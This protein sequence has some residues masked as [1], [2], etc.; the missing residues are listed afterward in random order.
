LSPR[1]SDIQLLV[2]E[3][4]ARSKER[5]LL[6]SAGA[7]SGKTT[8]LVASVIAALKANVPLDRLLVVTFTD[9]AAAEMKNKIYRAMGADDD[10]APLRLR[11]PQAWIST[12][13]SFCQRLLRDHFEKAGVDPRF[14]VLSE[15]D[16]RLLLADATTR[17]FHEHYERAAAEDGESLFEQ[18]VEMCG[19]GRD[20]ENLRGVVHALL[21]YARAS[22][23]P[24]RFL[25]GHLGRLPHRATEWNDL[26]WREDYARRTAGAW[27]AATGMLRALVAETGND[28]KWAAC[29][30]GIESVDP[31]L[32]A[33]P[34]GQAEAVTRL[35]TMGVLAEDGSLRIKL[36][37]VPRGSG[38]QLS[39]LRKSIKKAFDDEWLTEMP[40]DV[41]RAVKDEHSASRYGLCLLSLAQS[42]LEEY[43]AAKSRTGRLDFEDL[44]IR[45]LRLIREIADTGSAIRFERVFIDEFQDVNGLQHRLLEC[46]CDPTRIFRVGDVKQSI[47]Q[48]RL[49]DPGI[50]RDLGVDRPV[51]TQ[52]EGAPEGNPEWNVLLPA[53]YR[54]LRPIL[55]VVNEIARGLFFEEEIGTPYELQAL[56]PGRA[57]EESAPDVELMLVPEEDPESEDD[58]VGEDDAERPDLRETEWLAIAERIRELARPGNLIRDPESGKMRQIEYSDIAILLRAQSRAPAL[59]RCLEEEGI[60]CSV[61]TGESFFNATEVRDVTNVLRVADNMLDDI[62]LAAALRSPAL[63]W[64]DA[65]ILSV[66]LAYPRALHLAFALARLAERESGEARYVDALLPEDEKSRETLCGPHVSLP[67]E[68][69]FTAVPG[70]ARAAL[71]GFLRWRYAAGVCE[72]PELVARVLRETG[73]VRSVAS[74]PGGLR[75]QANLRKFVGIARRYAQESGHSLNRFLR[76]LDLL[77]E[78]GAKIFEAPL[79]GESLP[80]VRILTIHKAKGLEFPVV[81]VA[82]MGRPYRLGGRVDAIAPGHHYIGVR[83]LDQETYVLRK[84]A[85]LRLLADEARANE[86]A[87]EKRVLYVALTRARDRLILSG[88]LSK[89]AMVPD[90]HRRVFRRAALDRDAVGKAA[91]QSLLAA[92]AHP[93]SWV[94]YTLPELP[95]AGG[96]VGRLPLLV[97]WIRPR[98][99]TETPPASNPVREIE[100]ALRRRESVDV[101]GGDDPAVKDAIARA[102]KRPALPS[103]GLLS[104]ARGKIW[105]TEFKSGLD[106]ATQIDPDGAIE[107]GPDEPAVPLIARDAAAREGTLIHAALERLDMTGLNGGNLDARLLAAAAAIGGLPEEPIEVLRHGIGRLLDLPLGRLLTS[108]GEIHREVA[109]S[110]RLPLL[111]IAR[112]LPDLRAEIIASPDWKEWIEED[113]AGALRIRPE[114]PPAAGDPWV[115]VQGRIDAVLR[116]ANGWTVLD[117]KSD[118]VAG[119]EAI[120][121]R[122]EAYT[123][124]ME[125]YRRAAHSLFGPPVRAVVFFLRPGVLREMR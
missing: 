93:I 11:L 108:G 58:G 1:L 17:V 68:P 67:A 95:A 89:R 16:A 24:E 34:E 123:G 105:A 29:L 7:G 109:F 64:D 86:L 78:G 31:A 4:L 56:V 33:S 42:V 97:R 46:V 124:Q 70:K 14:R 45:A 18:L 57:E 120:G 10:L 90:A 83:L 13:H 107:E 80:V 113:P 43:E 52:R 63:G 51:V 40:L 54:S 62:A 21:S 23:E 117:W 116:E 53:N 94:V 88:I 69:P 26:V 15:E 75:R 28:P 99:R 91:I 114:K 48:F 115:L 19:F 27:R 55:D 92:R 122:V 65:E 111:E 61:G 77:E 38:P 60:P 35:A 44:Q 37:S 82:E 74:L 118:R 25:G 30:R 41:D 106:Q 59:A 84:P 73:L 39:D 125:I 102:T 98:V 22:D 5:D 100:G 104:S 85:P 47:Y 2:V 66:R 36:P 119:D 103:P 101:P 12:I 112:W 76:W 32:L 8:I 81:I 49:A 20:G 3:Q 79:S 6:V 87:E 50:I 72:L 9:K 121:R 110:L 71:D 96:R